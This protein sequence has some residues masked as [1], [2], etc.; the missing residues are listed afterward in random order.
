[1]FTDAKE[2]KGRSNNKQI[3]WCWQPLEA[4]C[5]P[6]QGRAGLAHGGRRAQSKHLGAA[7]CG[8]GRRLASSQETRLP[9]SA[10]TNTPTQC[11]VC[12]LRSAECFCWMQHPGLAALPQPR[13]GWMEL[14]E[15]SRRST[16]VSGKSPSES[17]ERYDSTQGL[18][19]GF[20]GLSPT[21]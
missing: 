20:V 15:I 1:M 13:Q 3:S 19:T 12:S 16:K 21:K 4:T 14:A 9:S 6:W 18:W 11:Q 7:A 8:A 2:P 17:A 10:W 5:L